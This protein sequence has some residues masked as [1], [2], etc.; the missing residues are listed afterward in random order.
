MLLDQLVLDYWHVQGEANAR[1]HY[2]SMHP[3]FVFLMDD[4]RL[5]LLRDKASDPVECAACFVP[6]GVEMRS[7]LNRSTELRHVDVHLPLRHLKSLVGPQ[8]PLDTP[9]FMDRLGEI[10]PLVALIAGECAQPERSGGHAALLTQALLGEFFHQVRVKPSAAGAGPLCLATLERYVRAHLD[11]RI[12]V[13]ALARAAGM[14]RS[15]FNRVFKAKMQQSPY[16]WVLGRRID[17]AKALL[18]RGHSFA[19]AADASGFADQAHFNRV[20]KAVTGGVPSV[21]MKEQGG[22]GDDLNLQDTSAK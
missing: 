14:S 13:E 4:A 15:H 22:G 9:L 17:H 1:G 7:R 21:W 8:V 12:S 5:V 16:Q 11:Q 20:F 19:H 6:A 3:R 2:A 18:A 10:A